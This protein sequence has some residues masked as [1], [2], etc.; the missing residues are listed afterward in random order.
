[1][2]PT[3]RGRA[4]AAAQPH[5]LAAVIAGLVVGSTVPLILV[6]LARRGEVPGGLA[7]CAVLGWAVLVVAI[8]NLVL[9]WRRLVV[10]GVV[11]D[12]CALACAQATRG[13]QGAYH[14]RWLLDSTA[15]ALAVSVPTTAVLAW[16]AT[17][18]IG[19]SGANRPVE[20]AFGA[21]LGVS[22]A[23]AST[24]HLLWR[25]PPTVRNGST[26]RS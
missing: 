14:A 19:G 10:A 5:F 8:M 3:R 24:A 2:M 23:A 18:L 22:I 6:G 16:L 26:P 20:G 11:Q 1:M 12:R 25:L 15:R 17:A 7:G 9:P 21:L 13:E 4:A